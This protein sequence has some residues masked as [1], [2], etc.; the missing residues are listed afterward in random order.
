MQHFFIIIYM[1]K[2]NNQ[3]VVIRPFLNN[4]APK[5]P[6]PSA[7]IFPPLS[8]SHVIGT[9]TLSK[10]EFKRMGKGLCKV[11]FFP[12]IQKIFRSGW[13]GPG[14]IWMKKNRPK[15]KFC[16][17]TIPPCLAV[18]VVPRDVHACSIFI[19]YSVIM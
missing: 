4:I 12:K 11:N 6:L 10:R 8:I 5:F 2:N 9:T 7:P 14:L 15:I 19:P 3:S 18:H 13:V 1:P 16:V 17:C